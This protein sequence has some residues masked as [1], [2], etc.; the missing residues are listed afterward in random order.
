MRSRMCAGAVGLIMISATATAE[1]VV[2][3][4]V[5]PTLAAQS[6]T[7]E[8]FAPSGWHEETRATA[9]LNGDGLADVAFVLQATDPHN[10]IDAGP[11]WGR[12]DSNPRMLVVAVARPGGGYALAVENHTLIPR[13][14]EPDDNT[15]FDK[16][17]M[18]IAHA[19]V[20]VRIDFLRG[21]ATYTFRLH[22][23]NL[24]LIGFDSAGVLTMAGDLEEIS[25]NYATG[26]MKRTTG[27][28]SSDAGHVTWSRIRNRH[29]TIA[30]IDR[31]TFDPTQ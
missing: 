22:Q 8:G 29:V 25:I 26:R 19:A 3:P 17:G 7:I 14:T 30:D 20:R 9:D 6:Q 12:F 4:A 1:P 21:N 18:S 15:S 11:S 31:E 27:N 23:G 28:I 5:Y 24:E 10:M 2:P 16:S 13:K